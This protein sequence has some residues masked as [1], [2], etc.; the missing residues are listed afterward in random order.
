[1]AKARRAQPRTSRVV[2][3][4]VA[5]LALLVGGGILVWKLGPHT[6]TAG[7]QPTP[8]V[9]ASQQ[10]AVPTKSSSPSPK[11]SPSTTPT[12]ATPTTTSAARKALTACQAKVRAADA[13]ITEAKIGVGHWAR[14]VQ[15]QTDYNAH[16]LTNAQMKAEFKVTRL[17]GPADQS[18]YAAALTTYQSDDAA[19]KTVKGAPA[20]ITKPL[21]KCV[22][23]NEVQTPV[24]RAAAD[25]MADWASH[26]AAMR[27]SASG[28]V[29]DA[30]GVWIK[31]WR[32][33]PPH[34]A[35]FNKAIDRYDP[36]SC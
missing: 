7:P 21:G 11:P 26:L 18:R 4:M 10:T 34:I 30:Q 6:P 31:T 29:H 27:R 14:H 3:P 23:R 13:V 2:V 5:A 9:L 19:C 35:A 1:V 8:S 33:A 22:D 25:G 20:K 28:H 32:A 15:A 16:K 17:A 24:L 12:K 36:P